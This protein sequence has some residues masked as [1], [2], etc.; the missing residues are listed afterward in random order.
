[1]ELLSKGSWWRWDVSAEA[2]D[3]LS[4]LKWDVVLLGKRRSGSSSRDVKKVS[5]PVNPFWRN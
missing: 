5:E 4:P 1:L 3:P 2:F